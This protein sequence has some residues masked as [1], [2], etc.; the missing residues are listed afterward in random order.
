MGNLCNTKLNKNQGCPAPLYLVRVDSNTEE[1]RVGVDEFVDV[2]DPQVPEDGSVVEVSQVGHVCA[3]VELGRV[4]LPDLILLPDFF[5]NKISA[6]GQDL[7]PPHLS[8]G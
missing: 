3:A 7:H 2:S 6:S 1:A 5:L 8:L 4:N